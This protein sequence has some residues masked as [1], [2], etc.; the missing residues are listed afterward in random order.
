[1]NYTP[2]ERNR[3]AQANINAAFDYLEELMDYPEEISSI[4]DGAIVIPPT[5]DEWVDQQNGEIA[6][7][8]SEKEQRPI[9]HIR[10]NQNFVTN[11]IE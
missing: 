4:P 6:K 11:Q 10:F 3:L 7:Y 1:M 2:D 9:V 5:G 8:W